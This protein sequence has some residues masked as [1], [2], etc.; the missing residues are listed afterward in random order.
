MRPTVIFAPVITAQSQHMA[1][2][3]M[4]HENYAASKKKTRPQ[5]LE[6]SAEIESVW[7]Q[8]YWSHADSISEPKT[9]Y[10]GRVFFLLHRFLVPTKLEI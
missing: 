6:L 5:F 10:C 1:E 2:K 4:R 3:R 9:H 8:P 7:N